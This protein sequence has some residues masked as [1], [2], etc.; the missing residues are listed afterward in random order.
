MRE[1][2]CEFIC[3]TSRK[4][5]NVQDRCSTINQFTLNWAELILQLPLLVCVCTTPQSHP[6]CQMFSSR[7]K[8][9]PLVCFTL[10]YLLVLLLYLLLLHISSPFNFELPITHS[11]LCFSSSPLIFHLTLPHSHFCFSLLISSLFH[12]I[13][14]HFLLYI[15]YYTSIHSPFF[16]S[17]ETFNLIYFALFPPPF[18]LIS[19]PHYFLFNLLC[20]SFLLLPSLMVTTFSCIVMLLYQR[21]SHHLSQWGEKSQDAEIVA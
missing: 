14:F 8:K 19:Q 20:S 2:P 3:V 9:T 21:C 4:G 1:A 13:H 12:I 6:N 18:Y 11:L 7:I 10:F 15:T 16:F 5:K 17:P